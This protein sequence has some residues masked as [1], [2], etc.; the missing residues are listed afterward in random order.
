MWPVKSHNVDNRLT[1]VPRAVVGRET[2]IPR[3]TSLHD[4][5]HSGKKRVPFSAPN[6]VC[7]EKQEKQP[8]RP[9]RVALIFMKQP[10]RA[11]T[12]ALTSLK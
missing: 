6:G 5:D 7:Q 10:H 11:R 1:L 12:R 4:T 2:E 9:K 8:I 3:R